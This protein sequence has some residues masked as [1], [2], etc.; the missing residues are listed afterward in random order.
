M[1]QHTSG[2]PTPAAVHRPVF[3][4]RSGTRLS[5][6]VFSC[7]LLF[8][9]DTEPAS[10]TTE[11]AQLQTSAQVENEDYAEGLDY[12]GTPSEAAPKLGEDFRAQENGSAEAKIVG[13]TKVEEGEFLDTVGVASL[14]DGDVGCTGVLIA[15]DVVLTA[16]HCISAGYS[17][18]VHIGRDRDNWQAEHAVSGVEHGFMSQHVPPGCSPVRLKCGLD[19]AVLLLEEPVDGVRPRSLA[20]DDLVDSAISYRAVGFGRL[21]RNARI[22]SRYK[23]EAR[24]TAVSNDC[25]GMVR[26][27]PRRP[28][29]PDEEVYGCEPSQ[30]I[31]AGQMRSRT[32]TCKGDSGGPLLVGPLGTG[33]ADSNDEFALAGL[34]SRATSQSRTTCGDGGVYERLNPNAR[35]WINGATARLRASRE[36]EG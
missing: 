22:I 31:V 28:N 10:D 29:R 25:T 7:L 24:V 18:R 6:A 36:E 17:A 20:S 2:P 34:T 15:P 4:Q 21:D 27:G 12:A 16:A 3:R 1:N 35:T 8:G 32:D 14:G 23:R 11:A 9:C 19:I 33:Q 13:G 30:E 26:S 5:S